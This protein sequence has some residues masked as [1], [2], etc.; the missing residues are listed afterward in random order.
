M[1]NEILEY[2]KTDRSYSAGLAL[3]Q[4]Y[5]HNQSFLKKFNQGESPKNLQILHY[6]L[7]KL[8]G[9]H[10]SVFNQVMQKPPEHALR[11]AQGSNSV[12][13]SPVAELVEAKPVP[14]PIE[15][16]PEQEARIKIRE[17]FPFLA[18]KNCPDAFK[19]L[20][21][22]M[23]TAYDNYVKSHADL[24]NVSDEKQAFNTA[25]R[26]VEN[27]LENQA[28]WKELN[29]YKATG[30]I[31]GEHPYFEEQNRRKELTAMSV[32]DLIKLKDNFEMNI[33]R[34]KKKLEDD[35]KPN[36][37]KSRQAKIDMYERDL[38]I[39]KSLLNINE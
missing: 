18:N 6:Q 16:K 28:I 2:F 36:L 11:Q 12:E 13:R 8:T 35:P 24:Y 37:V 14:E 19:I 1:Q 27:Y 23:L 33:W 30:K 29:Y 7:W 22:D 21:A 4:A 38:K 26:L 39:V 3:F 5:S 17:E 20:V 10:E 25:D 34:N 15:G 9:E 31:L 32:P